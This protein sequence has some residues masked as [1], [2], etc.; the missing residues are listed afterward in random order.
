MAP[1]VGILREHRAVAEAA[2]VAA[3]DEVLSAAQAEGQPRLRYL[4]SSGCGVVFGC[5]LASKLK[6]AET[7]FFL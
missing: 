4:M 6:P 7:H 3:V 5:Y 2:A 1:L